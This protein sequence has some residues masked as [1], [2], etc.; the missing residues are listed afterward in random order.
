MLSH[1]RL[2][3]NLG[4]QRGAV[5]ILVAAGLVMF[6]VF[7]ALALDIG[8]ALV[9][10]NELQN[11]ADA[12]ALA[13]ARYMGFTYEGKT[14]QEQADFTFTRAEIVAP[15]QAVS[16]DNKGGNLP[17]NMLDADIEIGKWN[18][19]SRTL[20]DIG[21]MNM[22]DAVRVRAR[23]DTTANGPI[24]TFFARIFGVNTADVTST[25]TA[26]L[27]GQGT[28]E[29]GGLPVPLGVSQVAA[30]NPPWCGKRIQMHPTKE[31]CA[32]WHTFDSATHSASQ[33]R[34]IL[35]DY[36][37]PEYRDK[38]F[39]SD[40]TYVSPEVTAGQSQVNFT[41]GDLGSDFPY[42]QAL[43]DYMRT[44]D[45]DGHDEWWTTAI[46]IYKEE[47]GGC[48]NVTGNTTIVG[49]ATMIISEVDVPPSGKIIY[50]DILCGVVDTGRGGGGD[51]GTLG[52]IP[53][54]VK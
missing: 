12:A 30:G 36:L 17:I 54:L 41:G 47:G 3:E 52:S 10:K 46:V 21:N 6:L 39:Q 22:P 23:R 25:A 40:A 16:L 48:G 26:A 18:S 8:Y 31:S 28:A 43:F 27:T 13:G 20:Y 44:R 19:G 34:Q 51:Y 38:Q 11:V 53:G 24:S 9:V 37:P 15:T 7:V 1:G 50:G 2:S 45:G 35:Q 49:F 4:G 29:E 33:L 42:F 32:G 14:Y 5:L